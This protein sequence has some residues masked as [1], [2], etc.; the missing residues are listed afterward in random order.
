MPVFNL[1][2][3]AEDRSPLSRAGTANIRIVLLDVNDNPPVFEQLLY[4]TEITEVGERVHI[5][6]GGECVNCN[7]LA[8]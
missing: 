8:A 2:L 4:R 1:L 5:P 3:T 6:T 7:S